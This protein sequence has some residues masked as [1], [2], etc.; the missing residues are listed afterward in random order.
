MSIEQGDKFGDATIR[1]KQRI[2]SERIVQGYDMNHF[3]VV[4][5][6]S[7]KKLEDIEATRN[8]G[9]YLDFEL[10]VDIAEQLNVG[11]EF[12]IDIKD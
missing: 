12:F 6:I 4:L 9:C 3:A 2:K 10:V 5:G 1:A 11:V 7:R 8:Y